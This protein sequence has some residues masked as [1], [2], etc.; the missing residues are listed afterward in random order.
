M[1]RTENSEDLSKEN[2]MTNSSGKKSS[3]GL[4]T[5]G[6]SIK[7]DSKEFNEL[8]IHVENEESDNNIMYEDYDEGDFI[9]IDDENANM[10]LDDNEMS[11]ADDTYEPNELME[12]KVHASINQYKTR[13]LGSVI[14]NDLSQI[15]VL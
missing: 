5:I 6:F 10:K 2:E 12:S 9:N 4:K 15:K 3:G 13:F 8:N 14:F 1:K 7:A 11:M